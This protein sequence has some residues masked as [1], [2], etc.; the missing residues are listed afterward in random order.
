MNKREIKFR[1]FLP[2]AGIMLEGV[3]VYHLSSLVSVDYEQVKEAVENKGLVLDDDESICTKDGEKL[4]ELMIGDDWFF[5]K[6]EDVIIMQF[7]DM[8]A[9]DEVDIYEGDIIEIINEDNETVR[10][11]CEYGTARRVMNGGTEVDI[12]GFYLKLPNGLKTFPIVNNYLGKHDLEI[13]SVVGNIYENPD[14]IN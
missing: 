7:S 12:Q 9:K 11:V 5:I 6:E 10:V 3:M 14:L 4:M 1:A 2:K 8:I 13:M